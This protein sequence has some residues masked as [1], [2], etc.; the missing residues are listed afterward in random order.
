MDFSIPGTVFITCFK[1]LAPCLE[2][3]LRG[4]GFVPGE[5]RETGV[6]IQASLND[7]MRLNLCLRSALNV[8]FR[9]KTFSCR[10]GDELYRKTREVAWT[11]IVPAGE[12][13]SVSARVDTASI[14]NSMYASLR[15]KDAIVDTIRDCHG[16]RPDA[17]AERENL[18]FQL[19]WRG[20]EAW[21]YLNTSGRKIAD[22]GYRRLPG[23]APLREPLAAALVM[24]TGY[25][26]TQP[27]LCPMCGS[28]TLPIEA[29]LMAQGRA[30]GLLRDNYGF[31]HLKGFD[32]EVWR[33][34][35][36]AVSRTD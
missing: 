22:R 4:L 2:Q 20:E 29:V 11:D 17:G 18:V 14:N 9:L 23:P 35:R 16:S 3:E 28:G 7:C 27:L 19:H 12:Y 36:K 33:E 10:D 31:M 25:D 15:V 8:L 6:E 21:L 32:P 34:T 24:A 5:T 13:I 30:P 1:G 26:G